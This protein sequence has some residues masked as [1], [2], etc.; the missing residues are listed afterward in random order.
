MVDFVIKCIPTLELKQY[1]VFQFQHTLTPRCKL[2]PR[3]TIHSNSNLQRL[4]LIITI[5]RHLALTM[6][7][8]LLRIRH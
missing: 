7:F 1:I 5:T 3:S 4:F 2:N 8:M 6:T